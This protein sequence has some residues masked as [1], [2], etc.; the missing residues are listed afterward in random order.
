MTLGANFTA[1][2]AFSRSAIVL[3]TRGVALPEG[4]DNAT[5]VMDV[6]DPVSGLSFEIAE[7]K[8]FLQTV[9]HVRLAWGVGMVKPA[10]AA[11]LLG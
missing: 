3:A 5:A 6:T 11:L 9:Y 1:N 10:H 7:Y 2:M 8:Q 4:G